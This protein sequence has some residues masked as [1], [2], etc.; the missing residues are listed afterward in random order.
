MRV[1]VVVDFIINFYAAIF[2]YLSVLSVSNM[3]VYGDRFS[4]ITIF[5]MRGLQLNTS[6]TPCCCRYN[7]IQQKGC[8]SIDRLQH[9]NVLRG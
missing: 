4:L 6:T 3:N 7:E 1:C 2:A 8:I 5:N 9:I